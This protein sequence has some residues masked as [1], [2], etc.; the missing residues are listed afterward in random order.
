LCGI[1]YYTIQILNVQSL[2]I[3][4]PFKGTKVGK[5]Y[6]NKIFDR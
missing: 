6:E 3:D 5:E 2:I 1:R 4:V